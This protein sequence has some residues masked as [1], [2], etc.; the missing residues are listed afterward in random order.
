MKNKSGSTAYGSAAVR[1]MEQFEPEI[2]RLFYDPVVY[3][4]T[5]N[6]LRYALKFKSVR[7]YFIRSSEKIMPGII[8]AQICRTKYIDE[9]TT[10][11]LND[12]KQ[13]LVLGAG[14]DTRAYRLKEIDKV[15]IYE[16]DLPEIQKTK[17]RKLKKYLSNFPINVTFIP[18]DFNEEKLEDVLKNSSFDRT[19]S[20]LVILE[21]V[22]QYLDKNSVDEVF[23]FVSRLSNE[24]YFIFT[25]ILKDVIERKRADGNKIMEW[26]EKKG[27]TFKFG[28]NP[29]DINLFL[30]KYS[31]ETIED[32]NTEYY[33]RNYLKPINRNM[34]VTELERINFSR[35][36]KN[37][38]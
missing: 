17:K 35:V 2:T 37:I 3:H 14:F 22:T 12:L 21:A 9:K 11:L 28:I 18:I 27:V 25:Y 5:N 15:K 8:G 4:I 29:S 6:I 1:L 7:N 32:V 10:S 30:R 38:N 33:Q 16:I 36:N 34:L 13:I 24:S 23:K 20:T 26:S 31:L 19:K